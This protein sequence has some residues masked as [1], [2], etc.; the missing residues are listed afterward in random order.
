MSGE[1]SDKEKAHK[2]ME[3]ELEEALEESFPASDPAQIV[4]PQR[5]EPGTA[6]EKF[7]DCIRRGKMLPRKGEDR[8]G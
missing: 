3:Q 2:Q 6:K 1:A 7:E 8:S 4:Q 5:A